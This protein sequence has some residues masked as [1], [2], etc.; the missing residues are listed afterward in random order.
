MQVTV[1]NTQERSLVLSAMVDGHVK[2]V[3]I[4]WAKQNPEN[5]SDTINGSE[6]VDSDFLELAK[7]N[8]VVQQ[9]FKSGWLREVG[10]GGKKAA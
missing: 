1:T 4:P 5:R 2:S 8:P 9:Y 6:V 7:K 3:A 10:S